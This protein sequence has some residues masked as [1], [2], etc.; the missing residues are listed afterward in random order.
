MH[1]TRDQASSDIHLHSD[2]SCCIGSTW[3]LVG[4]DIARK[5][6]LHCYTYGTLVH[7]GVHTGIVLSPSDEGFLLACIDHL[8]ENPP[9]GS[10]L[11]I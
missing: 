2:L 10:E 9:A 7:F 3:A 4:G 1:K 5:N 6:V 11:L 8:F